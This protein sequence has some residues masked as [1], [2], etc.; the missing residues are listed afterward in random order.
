MGLI[1]LLCLLAD[2][3]DYNAGSGKGIFKL[4]EPTP[5]ESRWA[6]TIN[7]ATPTAAQ[8]R[9]LLIHILDSYGNVFEAIHRCGIV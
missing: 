9:R 6:E 3:F 7:G 5:P 8:I 4:K 1:I 2:A